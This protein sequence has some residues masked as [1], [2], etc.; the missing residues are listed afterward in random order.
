MV[1]SCLFG[2]LSCVLMHLKGRLPRL[3]Y[4]PSDNAK[5]PNSE[6]NA[7]IFFLVAG[8]PTY[9]ITVGSYRFMYLNLVSASESGIASVQT[10]YSPNEYVH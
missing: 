5:P 2:Q 1:Q 4:V 8:Q 9:F 6:L 7:T 3:L 10:D